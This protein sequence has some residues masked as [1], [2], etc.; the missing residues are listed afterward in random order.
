MK[1]TGSGVI[2]NLSNSF[3][4]DGEGLSGMGGL[5]AGK[6]GAVNGGFNVERNGSITNVTATRIA[7]ILAGATAVNNVSSLNAVKSITGLKAAV[8]GADVDGDR[9][10]DWSEGG[11]TGFQLGTDTPIDGVVIVKKDQFTPAANT[12]FLA[13]DADGNDVRDTMLV[14]IG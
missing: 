10:F 8:I 4:V 9:Q 12:V 14:F 7:A 13:K 6:G 2:G 5:I 1:I 11:T 3:E